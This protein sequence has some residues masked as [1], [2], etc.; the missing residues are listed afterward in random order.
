MKRI[1]AISY[2]LCVV[3]AFS[4]CRT[5]KEVTTLSDINGEWNIIEINGV[6]VVPAPGKDFPNIGFDT[7]TG[8][9]FGNSGCNRMMGSFDA[10]KAGELALGPIAGT[11]MMCPDM[12]MENNVLNTLKNVTGY[13]KAGT[14]KIALL[15]AYDRPVLVLG[16]RVVILPISALAGEWKVAKVNGYAIP[17]NLESKPFVVFDLNSNRIH[18]N[19]GCNMINGGIVTEEGSPQAISFPAVSVTMMACPDMDAERRILDAL[20]EVKSF[21][22][23]PDKTAVLYDQ[24]GAQLIVLKR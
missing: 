4:S 11:R 14:G 21:D 6:T 15:N 5:Q 10:V 16:P 19:A 24:N 23:L 7:S 20:N 9:L 17:A 22:V 12:T 8:R 3:F 1:S 18:G 2:A 13:R